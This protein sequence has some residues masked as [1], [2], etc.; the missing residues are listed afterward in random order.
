MS[1]T[2]FNNTTGPFSTRT[3]IDK[4]LVPKWTR[5]GRPWEQI[6]SILIGLLEEYSC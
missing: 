4:T 5:L 2:M 6:V 3:S 1:S